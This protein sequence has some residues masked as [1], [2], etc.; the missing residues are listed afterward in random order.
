M[1]STPKSK[2]NSHKQTTFSRRLNRMYKKYSNK[3]GRGIPFSA[4][5]TKRKSNRK[6]KKPA[7]T[8]GSNL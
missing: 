3:R 1:K 4:M 5:K 8:R 2:I 7:K 6:K